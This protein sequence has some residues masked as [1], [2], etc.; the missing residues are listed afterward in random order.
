MIS[1]QIR[2]ISCINNF[3]RSGHKAAITIGAKQS[4]WRIL[5]VPEYEYRTRQNRLKGTI[6]VIHGTL[7][8]LWQI[9]SLL[10]Y[11]VFFFKTPIKANKD[12]TFYV[13][14]SKYTIF[15]FRFAR[16]DLNHFTTFYLTD[17][18]SY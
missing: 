6:S 17:I 5:R 2:Q 4:S 12:Q 10:R 13:T 8:T 3:I 9:Y 1:G 14:K 11:I 16:K 15:H 7:F 18:N